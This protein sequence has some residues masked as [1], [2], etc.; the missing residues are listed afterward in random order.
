MEKV[1]VNEL[2][3]FLVMFDAIAANGILVREMWALCR[4]NICVINLFSLSIFQSLQIN[5][6]PKG[7]P[8]VLSF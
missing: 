4:Q 1:S 7:V 6:F 3:Y 2:L 5:F 8:M